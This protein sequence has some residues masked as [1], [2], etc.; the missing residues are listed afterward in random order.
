MA[1]VATSTVS[2]TGRTRQRRLGVALATGLGDQATPRPASIWRRH[3]AWQP[4]CA[5][6]STIDDSAIT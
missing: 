5:A 2:N 4:Q 6:T 3:L 1:T